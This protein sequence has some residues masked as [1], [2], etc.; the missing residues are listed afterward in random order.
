[1]IIFA[2]I[3][4]HCTY[5]AY[6]IQAKTARDKNSIRKVYH[7]LIDKISVKECFL[8]IL[9]IKSVFNDN[10]YLSFSQRFF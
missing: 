8:K 1:V 9:T 10:F 2:D 6:N 5:Q 7:G 3:R 4:Y